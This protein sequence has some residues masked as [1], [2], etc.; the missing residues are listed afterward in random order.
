MKTLR[1]LG[2]IAVSASTVALL[3]AT[4]AMAA[5]GD[6][7]TTFALAGNGISVSV[8]ANAALTDGVSGDASVSGNLGNV[9]V[10]DLRGSNTPWNASATSTTFTTGTGNPASTGVTY[11]TGAITSTGAIVIS[12]QDGTAL[13]ST[14]TK[15][16]GPTTIVGN[17]T[18]TW[19]PT[20]TVSLPSNA[21]VGNYSGTI[22]TSVI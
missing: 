15:V 4:P 22:N 3:T 1:I 18:A 2:V 21:I 20:L 6:T 13:T 17:N 8:Q 5:A 10:T 12:P 9:K 19:N 11:G 14:A 16:A 7:T